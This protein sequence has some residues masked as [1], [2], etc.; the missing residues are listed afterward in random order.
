MGSDKK[1]E[2]KTGM[3]DPSLTF[4][5]M[6]AI[7]SSPLPGI[8]LTLVGTPFVHFVV[9]GTAVPNMGFVKPVM[10]QA[11]RWKRTLSQMTM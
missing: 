2:K 4:I 11:T 7:T 6:D 3:A 9:E 5:C 1:V 8:G 10:E